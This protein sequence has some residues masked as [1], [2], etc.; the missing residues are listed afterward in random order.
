MNKRKLGDHFIEPRTERRLSEVRHFQEFR[1]QR[2]FFDV[3]D[4]NRRFKKFEKTY[5]MKGLV[6]NQFGRKGR[7]VSVSSSVD[8]L[9]TVKENFRADG[10]F[11]SKF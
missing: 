6:E 4:G 5:R 3:N 2:D 11:Y 10:E 8:N 1:T 7:S 9:A